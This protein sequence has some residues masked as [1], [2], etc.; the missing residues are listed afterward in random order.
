MLRWNSFQLLTCEHKSNLEIE[1]HEKICILRIPVLCSEPWA[2]A[3][4]WSNRSCTRC[5]KCPKA[6]AD[7]ITPGL[8]LPYF[9]GE[10]L[11]RL[12]SG[13]ACCPSS[14]S[15][16]H[17]MRLRCEVE[18]HDNS[19]VSPVT[20]LTS[21]TSDA[22]QTKAPDFSRPSHRI[23][24]LPF[25]ML[26]IVKRPGTFALSKWWNWA[27]FRQTKK[28]NS[29][30]LPEVSVAITEMNAPFSI[31]KC[32]KGAAC[33]YVHPLT[34]QNRHQDSPRKP[35]KWKKSFKRTMQELA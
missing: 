20:S 10:Y 3:Q 28:R 1:K 21:L 8:H 27:R 9:I 5:L 11:G 33:M 12:S 34:N 15:R 30:G 22:I 6:D 13:E 17:V 24:W 23:G 35:P 29:I 31:G 7:D 4:C 18:S 19:K 25:S 14:D 26:L 16:V 2:C 32:L